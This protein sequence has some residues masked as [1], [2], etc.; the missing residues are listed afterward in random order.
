MQ[1][2]NPVIQDSLDPAPGYY[3]SMTTLIDRTRPEDDPHRYVNA[4]EVPYIVL[5]REVSATSNICMGD[6][7]LVVNAR[8]GR[9]CW[10]VFADAGPRGHLGEGSVALAELLGIPA[11]ARTGGTLGQVCYF[12]FPGSSIGWP[13]TEAEKTAISAFLLQTH[14]GLE[15]FLESLR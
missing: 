13:V 7:A 6:L 14:Q 10:A 8:N 3:V 9:Q 15:T 5:P 4:E 11:D 12:V 2:G 1:G